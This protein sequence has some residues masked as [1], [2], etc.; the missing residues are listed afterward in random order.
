MRS[1]IA[2]A[3]LTL[4]LAAAA[5]AG[6][7][8][9]GFAKAPPVVPRPAVNRVLVPGEALRYEATYGP[10]KVGEGRLEVAGIEHV[11]GRPAYHLVFRIKGGVPLYRIDD[12]LESW[13]D[14]AS[15]SSLRFSKQLNEGRRERTQRF[16]IFPE[17]G[18]YEEVGKGTSPTVDEPLDDGAFFYFVRTLPLQT[19]DRYVLNRYFRPDRNPV[20][21]T[22]VRRERVKVPAGEFDAIVLR[23]V[24][25]TPGILS[26]ARRTELWVSDDD[27]RVLVQVQS[28]LPFG[29]ITLKLSSMTRGTDVPTVR[30]ADTGK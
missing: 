21:V 30:T 2:A 12:L 3:T 18:V 19:G 16:E 1:H 15:L 22:V 24:I 27:A 14:T 6:A 28:H 25:N 20:Q 29:T 11:R 5:A 8:E 9:A 4:A 7:Q 10:L 26:Q 13:I 17:R 23:P